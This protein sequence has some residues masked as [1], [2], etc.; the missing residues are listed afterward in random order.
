MF[1]NPAQALR[2]LRLSR[3]LRRAQAGQSDLANRPSFRFDPHGQLSEALDTELF[4]STHHPVLTPVASTPEVLAEV[5]RRIDDLFEA[6]SLDEGS[7]TVLDRY[8]EAWHIAMLSGVD[9]HHLLQMEFLD[10]AVIAETR[11]LQMTWDRLQKAQVELEAAEVSRAHAHAALTETSL[12]LR[13]STNHDV[14]LP[15]RAPRSGSAQD[16]HTRSLV[17]LLAPDVTGFSESEGV[18]ALEPGSRASLHV[19]EKDLADSEVEPQTSGSREDA[20]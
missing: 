5:V 2:T 8:L 16:L 7:Y 13:P 11:T 4:H 15:L 14:P 10:R 20:A 18:P 1:L 9:A 19:A 3:A 17:P 6:G 12:T